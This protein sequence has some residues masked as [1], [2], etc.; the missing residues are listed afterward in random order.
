[1]KNCVFGVDIG[2]TSVKIGCFTSDVQLL[3]KWEIPT[4]R[5]EEGAY[6][7]SDVAVSVREYADQHGLTGD[8]IT[9]IG[10]DV[11]GP[12]LADGIVNRSV[13]LGWGRFNVAGALAEE[14][15]KAFQTHRLIEVKVANDA[16]AAA[17][18]ELFDGAGKGYSSLVMVTLGTGIGGGVVIDKQ[19]LAGS[20]GAAGEIGHIKVNG[21]ETEKCGCGKCG[22][23]EQYASATGIVRLAKRHLA[24]ID[25]SG[26]F[27]EGASALTGEENLSAKTVMDAAKKGDTIA[28]AVYE[29]VCKY[30]GEALS[31]VCAVVDPQVVVIGGGVSAAGDFLISGIK[32]YFNASAFHALKDKPILRAKLGN[33]GGIYGAVR[34]V[35]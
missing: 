29:E 24:E 28:L 2:G 5:A 32:K 4:R 13:N 1:M 10:L 26:S 18:G 7:L 16:N 34:L 6:I 12:V 27:A 9:G 20:V 11:P 14:I 23:L 19:A 22:C 30:L 33:D 35:L 8:E 25:E 15:K 31:G 21:E 3:D 17:L